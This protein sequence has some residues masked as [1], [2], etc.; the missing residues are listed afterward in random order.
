MHRQADRSPERKPSRA[1]SA[2]VGG[3]SYYDHLCAPEGGKAFAHRQA[4]TQLEFAM[5]LGRQPRSVPREV[6]LIDQDVPGDHRQFAGGGDCG[7]LL[8][9]PAAD[10]QEECA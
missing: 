4:G 10:P 9:A 7:N 6:L 1:T 5:L 3:F 2:S 8:T